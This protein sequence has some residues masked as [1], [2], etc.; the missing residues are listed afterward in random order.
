MKGKNTGPRS[1]ETKRKISEALKGK[2][3]KERSEEHRKKISE[4]MKGNDFGKYK[5]KKN[6]G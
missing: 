5:K 1:E 6:W 3:Y 2:K 4:R